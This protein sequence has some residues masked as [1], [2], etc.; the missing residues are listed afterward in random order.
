[1]KINVAFSDESET[2]VIASF[3][4][5]QDIE[6]WPHQGL[7]DETDSRWIS[8]AAQFPSGA[9]EFVNDQ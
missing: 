3:G 2:T 8:Y 7:V 4:C 1:M 9:I 6:V 5:A